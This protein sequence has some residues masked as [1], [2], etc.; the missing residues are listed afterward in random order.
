M[1]AK[2]GDEALSEHGTT[3]LAIK[4]GDAQLAVFYHPKRGFMRCSRC[5]FPVES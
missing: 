4:Y 5:T 1:V 2:K 3:G